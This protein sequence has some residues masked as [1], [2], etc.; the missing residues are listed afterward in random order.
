M[1][2]RYVIGTA[3][4]MA[5]VGAAGAVLTFGTMTYLIVK[6]YEK[7]HG[8]DKQLIVSEY[9]EQS[10]DVGESV[11]VVDGKIIYTNAGSGSCPLIVESAIYNPETSEY[12][13]TLRDYSGS[14]CT[15]DYRGIEQT[16]SYADGTD[17]ADH[18][19]IIIE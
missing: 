13:L 5:F 9:T 10:Y 18:S 2:K 8:N 3:L 11:E 14:M 4:L 6:D 1:K 12:I 16:I 19:T 17:I 7:E 15:M